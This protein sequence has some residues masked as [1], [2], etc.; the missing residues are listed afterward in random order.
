MLT[1]TRP[2]VELAA[3]SAEQV[4]RQHRLT[5]ELAT[6]LT[7]AGFARHFV[8]ARWGGTAG[9]FGAL[10]ET[11]A[12]VGE[13]C[14]STAWCAALYAAHGRLAA[15]LPE[16]AQYELWGATPNVRIAA[17]VL[18]AAGQADAAPG[19]WRIGGRWSCASGVDHADWVL[20]AARTQGKAGTAGTAEQRIFAVPRAEV[21]VLDTWRNLGLQGTGSNSVV[22]DGTFVPAHRSFTLADLATV[23]PGAARCHAVPYQLVAALQFAA[24][25]LGAAR[26]A[27][28]AWTAATA[29]KRR[30]DGRPAREAGSVQ[31]VL[32]RASAEIHAAGLL[33]SHSA[34][35]ADEAQATP[36]V[37][38]ENQRD[39]AAA[40]DLCADAVTR[41]VRAGGARGQGEQDP[42]QRRWRDVTA[43]AGHPALDFEAAAAAHARE[44]FALADGWA[45]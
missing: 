44:G 4:N 27:L 26:G 12:E 21:A 24:P 16:Q 28:R 22:L 43:A 33:L 30:V 11:T 35:R 18:P 39:L 5:P 34:R 3:R 19:G 17:A 29:V 15:Y 25:M 9:T 36:L 6:A 31:V 41:L 2:L 45:A 23:E 7:A 20:L 13:A 10:A 37:V 40:A 8:P 42:V 14:A 32:G 38:A 1:D